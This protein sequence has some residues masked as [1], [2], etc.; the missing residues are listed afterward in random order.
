MNWYKLKIHSQQRI[1]ISHSE[2]MRKI[3][4]GDVKQLSDFLY[5]SI[6]MNAGWQEK[7]AL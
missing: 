6:T 4:T 5:K 3:E 7:A 2:L 1:Q